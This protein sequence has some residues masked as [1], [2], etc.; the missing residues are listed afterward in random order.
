MK[1]VY[2]IVFLLFYCSEVTSQ[3]RIP[4]ER[5]VEIAVLE[6]K[7]PRVLDFKETD[8]GITSKI[9]RYLNLNDAKIK[10]ATPNIYFE[11]SVGWVLEYDFSTSNYAGRYKENL[12]LRAN[13]LVITESRNAIMGIASN[14]NTITFTKNQQ[15]CKCVD[16]KD[17]NLESETVLRLFT[18][19]R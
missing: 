12:L 18:S 15:R 5:V 8:L 6:T 17:P 14:C 10:L 1:Y 11:K 2:A 7:T 3:I 16:K 13:K 19:H 9:R 4:A